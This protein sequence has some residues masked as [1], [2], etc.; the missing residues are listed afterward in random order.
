[1]DELILRKNIND[2]ILQI[3]F[4]KIEDDNQYKFTG[5]WLKRV[6]ETEKMVDGYFEPLRKEAYA[7]YKA[8][9]DKAKEIKSPLIKV[10]RVVKNMR[11]AYKLKKDEELRKEKERLLKMVDN[12]TSKKEL[13]KIIPDKVEDVDGIRH[14]E[15]YVFEIIDVDKIP[16]KYMKPDEKK[17][18]KVVNAMGLKTNIPG[19]KVKKTL[20]ERVR[21]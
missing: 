21:A 14:V 12:E 16:R 11:V 18:Q 20:I 6:K 3:S 9:L 10:E 13:K 5:E 8:I 15:K 2:I 17:I 1:M 7:R 4:K 19:I